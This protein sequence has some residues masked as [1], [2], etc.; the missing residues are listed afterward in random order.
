MNKKIEMGKQY[1]TRDG[2]SVRILCVDRGGNNYP[3]VAL[4]SGQLVYSFGETGSFHNEKDCHYLDLIEYNPA[5]D[6]KMDQAIWV[7][8]DDDEVWY[9]RHFKGV[10]DNGLVD[11]WMD[12]RTSHTVNHE[13]D[14][15]TEWSQWSV[16]NPNK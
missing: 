11:C 14:D 9:P 10:S 3:V 12:G 16:T 13:R 6:L 5:N 1:R 15:F 2:R 7:K 4:I 8:D